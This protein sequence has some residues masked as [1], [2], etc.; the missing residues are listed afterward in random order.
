MDYKQLGRPP[1]FVD[2]GKESSSVGDS[3]SAPCSTAVIAL[4]LAKYLMFHS[5]FRFSS[6]TREIP[7]RRLLRTRL[8]FE[9]FLSMEGASAHASSCHKT[10][11]YLMLCNAADL[12]RRTQ[13][14][15]CEAV[16]TECSRLGT[17][18]VSRN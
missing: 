8:H 2:T 12:C 7:R 15:Q 5:I 10:L 11:L 6:V 17:V 13:G 14:S 4:S 18:N 3:G 16:G 1:S 9:D